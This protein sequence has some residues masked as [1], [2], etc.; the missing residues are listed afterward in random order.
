M[1][2]TITIEKYIR[3]SNHVKY[4][5]IT[6]I[7]NIQQKPILRR[8]QEFYQYY[9]FLKESIKEI[10]KYTLS[11]NN[12][13]DNN[14]QQI[15]KIKKPPK[16]PGKKYF[17]NM[18]PNFL[19]ERQILLEQFLNEIVQN[20]SLLKL[21]CTLNFLEI[22]LSLIIASSNNNNHNNIHNMQINQQQPTNNN[23]NNTIQN[24]RTKTITNLKTSLNNNENITTQHLINTNLN[25]MEY[26]PYYNDNNEHEQ[27]ETIQVQRKYQYL[28]DGMNSLIDILYNEPWWEETF[29]IF[30]H[31]CGNGIFIMQLLHYI[32][33]SKSNSYNNTD[34]RHHHNH[35]NEIFKT[36][37][38]S[39]IGSDTN[40][41]YIKQFKEQI[42]LHE[43]SSKVKAILSNDTNGTNFSGIYDLFTS[44]FTL[45]HQFSSSYEIDN[46]NNNNMLENIK[47]YFINAKRIIKSEGYI[48]ICEIDHFMVSVKNKEENEA[49]NWQNIITSIFH[50]LSIQ[51][52]RR[53][54]F[55]IRKPVLENVNN[56]NNGDEEQ[57]DD[58]KSSS[59]RKIDIY[60]ESQRIQKFISIPCV[61]I[62]GKMPIKMKKKKKKR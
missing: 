31:R 10:R 35:L 12:N 62:I 20:D 26:I 39:I 56:E 16:L 4:K 48:I 41:M 54:K 51:I 37:S 46:N 13:N 9:Q 3:V 8:Y 40:E 17:A 33:S 58:N 50:D 36:L 25:Q 55:F 30:Q 59:S 45:R 24:N 18:D 34:H 19:Q 22:P 11:N 38:M 61:V 5:I 57:D 47:Q 6:I 1:I 49:S 53:H 44:I 7:N 28:I 42:Q 60:R 27:H 43:M 23:N 21:Y 2:I 32:V 52:I 14:T 15:K 29:R